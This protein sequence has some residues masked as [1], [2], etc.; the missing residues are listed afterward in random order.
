MRTSLGQ[1]T[2]RART[3]IGRGQ[4]R[5]GG[6]AALAAHRPQLH[7]LHQGVGVPRE[8][9][10]L[11]EMAQPRDQLAAREE[12]LALT[13]VLAEN[14]IEAAG[15]EER[16]AGGF[17]SAFDLLRDGAQGGLVARGIE[18]RR[19]AANGA[20][21][22]CGLRGRRPRAHG[23][24]GA[25]DITRGI[26]RTQARSGSPLKRET[27]DALLAIN[28]RFYH[29]AAEA[30]DRTREAPWPGW[31]RALRDAPRQGRALDVGCGNARLAAFLKEHRPGLD[32]L[33]VDASRALLERARRR[34]P[35]ARLVCADWMRP[36]GLPRGPFALV[37]L[38]GVLHHV[39]SRAARA[40]LL[41]ALAERLAPEGHLVFTVWRFAHLE[42]F[43]RRIVPW[44]EPAHGLD[45]AELEPG[46]HL[47]R[48]GTE[49]DGT[50]RYCHDL[51]EEEL[52]AHLEALPLRVADRFEDDGRDATN[53]YL[54]LGR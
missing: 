53:L 37:A 26:E 25:Q 2:Q 21:P 46:D 15:I 4:D 6:D 39:P 14:P 31:T 22:A 11:R 33:G 9:I 54:V 24:H 30:F 38:F 45:A 5:D 52:G 47:L 17:E 41:R 34:V 23:L 20:S 28:R 10:A 49:A 44:S 48:W 29:E 27:R 12:T 16:R 1:K 32:Y 19:R 40:A 18:A 35:A 8:G 36:L 50:L 51:D 13:R 7:A 3:G 43:R 42:R